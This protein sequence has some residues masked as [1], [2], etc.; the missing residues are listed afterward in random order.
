MKQVKLT[1]NPTFELE[2]MDLNLHCV[3]EN[4]QQYKLPE[5]EMLCVHSWAF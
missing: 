3:N 5:Y 2:W 1:K 4:K